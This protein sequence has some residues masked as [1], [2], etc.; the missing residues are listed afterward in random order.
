MRES[1]FGQLLVVPALAVMLAIG[2]VSAAHNDS[3]VASREQSTVGVIVAHEPSS[4]N[5][6]GY[7]FQAGGRDYIG[8]ETPLKEES[9]LGQSVTVYFDS[10]QPAENSL[11]DFA[12]LAD[13]WRGRAIVVGVFTVLFAA[14]ALIMRMVARKTLA[15][16]TSDGPSGSSP[17]RETT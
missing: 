13:I 14:V 16:T 5:S 11:T 4:H 3:G 1:F 10:L 12:E 17:D 2:M 6:Y 15:K 8:W 9:K 7:K